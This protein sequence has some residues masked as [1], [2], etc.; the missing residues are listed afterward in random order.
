MDYLGYAY[1]QTAQDS[2]AKAV[3]GELDAFQ[4]STSSAA[5]GATYAV[6]AIPPVRFALERR[7]WSAAASLSTP[8]IGFP[9]ER[10]PWAEA[11]SFARALGE[12]RTGN[13]A[14]AQTEI[15][16]LQSLKE[17]LSAANTSASS[18]RSGLDGLLSATSF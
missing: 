5:K 6:A 17:K 18:G 7:D 16:N 1:L 4:R 12:A 8:A 14:G 10:F 11:I 2:A 9:L 3:V 13:I 15:A